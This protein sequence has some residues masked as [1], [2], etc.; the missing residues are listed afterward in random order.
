M[1]LAPPILTSPLVSYTRYPM[2]SD[3]SLSV[4]KVGARCV[5]EIF[6]SP[7][8]EKSRPVVTD[9]IASATSEA[10]FALAPGSYVYKFHFEGQGGKYKLKLSV[11]DAELVNKEFDT[12]FGLDGRVLRF[13]VQ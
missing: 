4:D 5:G 12:K 10:R 11:D 8:K 2:I 6:R 7:Y 1:R 9:V 3:M 13:V